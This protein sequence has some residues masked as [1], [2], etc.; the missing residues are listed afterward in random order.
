MIAL[1]GAVAIGCG[2]SEAGSKATNGAGATGGSPGTGGSGGSGNTGGAIEGACTTPE[3]EAVYDVL[4]YTNRA[5]E[6]QSGTDAASGI[7]A[8][9][10]RIANNLGG[11]A[12]ETGMVIQMIPT[13]SDAAITALSDCDVVCTDMTIE[14]LT[15]ENLTPDCLSCYGTSVA[16][17]AAFCT[18]E[19]AAD[20]NAPGCV[21]CRIDNDCTPGFERCSGIPQ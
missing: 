10:L 13:P 16:C 2:T 15:G 12:L 7:A 5:N 9:C 21:Q 14:D 8:D 11:C 3:N 1:A 6:M 20:T 4:E 18:V 19:C 17:G